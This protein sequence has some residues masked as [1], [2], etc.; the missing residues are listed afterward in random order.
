[1]IKIRAKIDDVI[2]FLRANQEVT[3]V[4][5]LVKENSVIVQLSSYDTNFLQYESNLT[6]VNHKNYTVLAN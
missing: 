5:T 1:M 4:V 3:G 2:I 6:V